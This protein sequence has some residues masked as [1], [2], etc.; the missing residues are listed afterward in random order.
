LAD[1]VGGCS[2]NEGCDDPPTDLEM[3]D[4]FEPR[5]TMIGAPSDVLKV[6]FEG[7][8][9]PDRCCHHCAEEPSTESD[10]ETGPCFPSLERRSFERDC[11][12]PFGEI[13]DFETELLY[14]SK[15]RIRVRS[16]DDVCLEGGTRT[17]RSEKQAS[18]FHVAHT[19]VHLEHYENA[20]R[21]V[22]HLP[23]DCRA[24]LERGVKGG[25]L[26]ATSVNPHHAYRSSFG[27]VQVEETV[28]EMVRRYMGARSR[29]V[30]SSQE[31]GPV[32]DYEGVISVGC[33]H[34]DYASA[35]SEELASRIQ[36]NVHYSYKQYRPACCVE[37]FPMDSRP[38]GK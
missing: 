22:Y 13:K 4:Y 17:R 34:K 10:S 36:K 31:P 24:H 2:C 8:W 29:I 20:L 27:H 15:K 6:S 5:E 38:F 18:T 7:G 21:S 35:S 9:R 32:G 11:D 37:S 30:I 25:R 19:P 23:S 16:P 1:F 12:R 14:D 28:E 33:A 26:P 3:G